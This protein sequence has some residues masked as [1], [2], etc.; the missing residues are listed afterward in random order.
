MTN[1]RRQAPRYAVPEDLD[2]PI[3]AQ[4]VEDDA[5]PGPIG[6][7]PDRA[8][9]TAAALL[10]VGPAGGERTRGVTYVAAHLGDY[11]PAERRGRPRVAATRTHPPS[12]EQRLRRLRIR[13]AY[14]LDAPGSGSTSHLL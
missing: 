5:G 13:R 6:P 12:P 7:G 11:V 14:D 2:E 9:L 8:V 1:T 4:I 3:D 10:A